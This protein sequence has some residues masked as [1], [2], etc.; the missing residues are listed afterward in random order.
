MIVRE[1]ERNYVK[2][3]LLPPTGGLFAATPPSGGPNQE[4]AGT[5]CWYYTICQPLHVKP[6]YRKK[7]PLLQLGLG[8]IK[9]R[10]ANCN[11]RVLWMQLRSQPLEKPPP[12][13]N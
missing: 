3:V 2:R 7:L 1:L 12:S 4:A 5:L 13:Q 6:A 8:S 10:A 9:F 11:V